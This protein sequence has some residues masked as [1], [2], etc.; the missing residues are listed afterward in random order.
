MKNLLSI[1]GW[2]SCFVFLMDGFVWKILPYVQ[3]PQYN[4]EAKRSLEPWS[5]FVSWVKDTI[6]HSVPNRVSDTLVPHS[7]LDRRRVE[8][9]C[10][11]MYIR[12]SSTCYP[13]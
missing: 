6:G 12:G 3:S 11:V 8:D 2:N 4:P 1:F 7:S 10:D 9:D 13:Y 5:S